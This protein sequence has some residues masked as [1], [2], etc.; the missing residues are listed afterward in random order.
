MGSIGDVA[1]SGTLIYPQRMKVIVYVLTAI[2]VV[3]TPVSLISALAAIAAWMDAQHI[4]P[5]GN[6]CSDAVGTISIAV[7]AIAALVAAG[8]ALFLLRRHV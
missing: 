5:D 4:C 6:Q 2:V 1:V 8:S 3:L 7:T